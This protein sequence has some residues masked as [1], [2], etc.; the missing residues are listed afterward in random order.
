MLSKSRPIEDVLFLGIIVVATTRICAYASEKLAEDIAKLLP[1][2]LIAIFLIDSKSIS[3]DAI[4]SSL[5]VLLEQIP[6]VAK[7][8]LFII[9]VEW[10]LRIMH[11]IFRPANQQSQ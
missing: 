11:W 6:K 7:Y 5:L 4:K 10:V 9:F 8:L 2:T 3:L 1:L